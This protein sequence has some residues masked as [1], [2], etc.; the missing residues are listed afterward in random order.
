MPVGRPDPASHYDVVTDAWQY[1]LGEDLHYGYFESPDQSLA[2]ATTALTR[3]LAAKAAL[4]PGMSVLDVG[5]GT[6]NPAL[7][8]AREYQ[9]SV[10]GISTSEVGI[11]RAQQRA[12]RAN[13]SGLVRFDRRDGTATAL[14]AGSFD[15][16]WVME[17]SHLMQRKDLLMKE[18]LRVLRPG[19]RLV[20]CDI[21]LLRQLPFREVLLLQNDIL[22]LDKVFG[23]AIMAEL[24]QYNRWAEEA[25]FHAITGTDI[26]REVQPTFDRWRANA[27]SNASVVEDLLGSE[28]LTQFRK[29]CDILTRFW[30]DW[31]GYGLLVAEGTR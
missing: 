6:G 29:A 21:V 22:V 1:L 4:E 25:G 16:I 8:L 23:R 26:S 12:A 15:R 7:F 31:L 2:E 28:G 14:D 11:Q 5:C 30:M 3:L 17:S 19:G 20:L 27:E 10:V 13:L 9:T 24:C 18:C